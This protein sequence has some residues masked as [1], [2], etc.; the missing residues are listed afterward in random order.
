MGTG[1]V[2]TRDQAWSPVLDGLAASAL[3]CVQTGLAA[4]ADRYCGTGAH[5]ALGARPGFT[6]STRPGLPPTLEAP[7]DQ[8]LAEAADLT[9]LRV[10]DRREGMDGPGLRRFAAGAGPLYV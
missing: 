1:L 2:Q 9:G 7:V 10:A 3:D 8:R 4:L 5:L 6:V